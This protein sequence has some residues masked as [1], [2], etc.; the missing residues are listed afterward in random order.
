MAGT[1]NAAPQVSASQ[2][3]VPSTAAPSGG[4]LGAALMNHI[5]NYADMATGKSERNQRLSAAKQNQDIQEQQFQR[6]QQQAEMDLHEHLMSIGA[7][8]V[9]N[10][11]AKDETTLPEY[12]QG[13]GLP[14][15][16]GAPTGFDGGGSPT[17]PAGPSIPQTVS[18]V[19]PADKSRLVSFKDSTGQQA[20]YELP[21]PEE[22]ISRQ[23]K[24][25]QPVIN[26]ENAAAGAKAAAVSQGTEQG[27]QAGL[28][29]SRQQ[30]G[31]EVPQGSG[32]ASGMKVLPTELPGI[33][34][35]SIIAQEAGSNI[36]KAQLAAASQVL[37]AATSPLAYRSAY[38]NLSPDLQQ[39][40][41]APE[42][43]DKIQSPTRARMLNMTPQD[44]QKTSLMMSMGPEEWNATVDQVAPPVGDSA[45]LNA[46]TKTLVNTAARRGDWE[47]AERAIK[48]A[49]D[50]LGRTETAVRSAKATE[51][52]KINLAAGEAAARAPVVSD[53]GMAMMAEAALA[54]NPPSSRNPVLYARVMDAAA[55]LAQSRGMN[56]QAAVLATTA[57]KANRT[58]FNQV[59][60][61]YAKLK[62]FGE[63]AE[64]NSDLLEQRIADVSDLGA[65]VLNTPLRNLQANFAGNPKVAAFRAALLPVQADFARILN[66]PTAAGALTDQAR[67]EMQAALGDGATPQMIHAALNVYRQDWRNRKETFEAQLKDLQGGTVVTGPAGTGAGGTAQPP[68]AAPAV[69]GA[70][71]PPPHMFN[72]HTIV[73][74]PATKRWVYQDGPDKGK[75]AE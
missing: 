3:S 47:G 4:G 21:T 54:G 24:L 66:S 42:A 15:S 50:Q 6:E 45:A 28:A 25:R 71:L 43:F 56:A 69:A 29:A 65:P 44:Q 73:P 61:Q 59:T 30:Y 5:R 60:E 32:V 11:M 22:Q 10:G 49:A 68:A 19:R 41:D 33:V 37:G 55:K 13:L 70:N 31:V 20:Q 17:A 9:V 52:I 14:A 35:G 46:R 57:A 38:R 72:G 7:R 67:N 34:Q 63:M 36:R 18:I 58:A 48:D 53:A 51:P 64:R 40:F 8:P 74:D 23:V 2:P 26:Q 62:P 39:Y 75:P 16:N 27:G 1:G 12:L